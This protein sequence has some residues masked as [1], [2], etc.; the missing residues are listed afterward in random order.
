MML[1]AFQIYCCIALI[2]FGF[3]L[4]FDLPFKPIE[5]AFL[6]GIFWPLSLLI[7]IVC[8]WVSRSITVDFG[9]EKRED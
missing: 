3:G 7:L 2:F 8:I 6:V 5:Y 1:L 4:W 9:D